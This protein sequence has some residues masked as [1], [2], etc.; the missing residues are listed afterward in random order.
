MAGI[1][2]HRVSWI[3]PRWRFMRWTSTSSNGLCGSMGP[4]EHLPGR[5]RFGSYLS[6]F[7]LKWRYPKTIGFNLDDLGLKHIKLSSANLPQ[8]ESCE[9]H[10]VLHHVFLFGFWRTFVSWCFWSWGQIV[11]CLAF[12]WRGQSAQ[13][14]VAVLFRFNLRGCTFWKSTRETSWWLESQK[15]R[16]RAWLPEINEG[17]AAT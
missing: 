15:L 8:A 10:H 7:T 12:F 3:Q 6:W 2:P 4:M 16:E 11:L 9:M 1:C 14:N 13:Q 5:A 17:S